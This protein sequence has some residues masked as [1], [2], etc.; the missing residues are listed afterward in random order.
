MKNNFNRIPWGL[1]NTRHPPVAAR[2]GVIRDLDRTL[3]YA[4]YFG[5]Y[6]SSPHI[7]TLF[8]RLTLIPNTT[9]FGVAPSVR[10]LVNTAPISRF[11]R[12]HFPYITSEGSTTRRYHCGPIACPTPSTPSNVRAK[13]KQSC[14]QQYIAYRHFRERAAQPPTVRPTRNTH[15]VLMPGQHVPSE[16]P[17]GYADGS[18]PTSHCP[19]RGPY[20]V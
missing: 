5:L 1:K 16:S 8:S 12:P 6:T 7:N 20:V 15:P 9:G 2:F 13:R 14:P 18:N 10:A 19:W 3:P 11:G 17:Y 4:W